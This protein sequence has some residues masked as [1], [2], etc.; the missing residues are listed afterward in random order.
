MDYSK[1]S[2]KRKITSLSN[3]TAQQEMLM[4]GLTSSV[5]TSQEVPRVLRKRKERD[6]EVSPEAHQERMVP[7]ASQEDHQDLMQR[8][9]QLASQEAHQDPRQRRRELDSEEVHQELSQKSKL[10]LDSP[11]AISLRKL[12][13]MAHQK[14]LLSQLKPV[15]VPVAQDLDSETV[16]LPEVLKVQLQLKND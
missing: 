7:Q 9:E 8:R 6:Q 13:K 10:I 5:Q 11:E 15:P 14:E 16:M 2:D 12:L 3:Q 1:W 4:M